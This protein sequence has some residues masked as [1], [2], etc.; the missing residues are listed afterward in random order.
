MKIIYGSNQLIAQGERCVRNARD[1]LT[2]YSFETGSDKE[3][4]DFH[5]VPN[6]PEEYM[7][8]YHCLNQKG[9]H[10][11]EICMELKMPASKVM[12]T[13]TILEMEGHISEHP[14]HI[15]SC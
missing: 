4:L 12:A 13:L 6:I 9:K 7:P 1:I 14:G 3:K 5:A 8:V 15:F 2:Y 11:D 10:I